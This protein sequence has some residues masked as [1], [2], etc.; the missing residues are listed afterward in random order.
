MVLLPG[1][2]SPSIV[3]LLA[4]QSG[5]T[6]GL[7]EE[8]A[9]GL[10]I[11]SLLVIVAIGVSFFMRLTQYDTHI[12]NIENEPFQLAYGVH[13]ALTKKREAFLWSVHFHKE[14]RRQK[15]LQ[16]EHARYNH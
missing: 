7:T 8:I 13:G 5:G 16:E 14:F 12:A 4:L 11:I 3:F 1:E 2:R 15:Y 6:A 9:A 10:G